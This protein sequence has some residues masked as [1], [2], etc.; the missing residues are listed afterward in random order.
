[1]YLWLPGS[2]FPGKRVKP[3]RDILEDPYNHLLWEFY[4]LAKVE[5]VATD[6]KESKVYLQQFNE[7]KRINKKRYLQKIQAVFARL[8][9]EKS[10]ER[11]IQK[12][13][14]YWDYILE[15][16]GDNKLASLMQ[17]TYLAQVGKLDDTQW[18]EF[19]E[20]LYEKQV[21]IEDGALKPDEYKQFVA[22]LY[23]V[24]QN[25]EIKASLTEL[26]Q[27]QKNNPDTEID[28][29]KSLYKDFSKHI[30]TKLFA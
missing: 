8:F 22:A 12:S 19:F 30:K 23:F 17:T 29:K 18:Q 20:I 4:K 13:F 24:T 21:K 14:G 16:Q 10:A 5:G 2:D 27:Q 3:W 25:K 7:E 26:L 11:E 15:G 9:P 28:L 1:M 6:T